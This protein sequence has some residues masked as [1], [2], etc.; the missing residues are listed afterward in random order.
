[1]FLKCLM[2]WPVHAHDNKGVSCISCTLHLVYAGIDRVLCGGHKFTLIPEQT[3]L[4][5]EGNQ[6]SQPLS[7]KHWS[8][9]KADLIL[10]NT[11]LAFPYA[12]PTGTQKRGCGFK[13]LSSSSN[14]LPSSY[15]LPDLLTLLRPGN[16][17]KEALLKD[18]ATDFSASLS[19]FWKTLFDF[20]TTP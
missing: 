2:T 16:I 15:A 12:L 4:H 5:R 20:E 6:Q 14:V 9:T 18:A 8:S 10:N 19:L 13:H 3:F 1:M 11:W 7:I 17:T